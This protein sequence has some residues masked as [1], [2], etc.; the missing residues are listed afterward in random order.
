VA[1]APAPPAVPEPAIPVTATCA[2]AWAAALDPRGHDDA[3]LARVDAF[4]ARCDDPALGAE[5]G[6]LRLQF[7]PGLLP[8]EE[9]IAAADAWLAAHPG[10]PRAVEAR[11]LRATVA[12]EQ[13]GDCGLALADYERVAAEASG[14]LAETAAAWAERCGDEAGGKDR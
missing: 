1:A 11:F 10:H 3:R 4:L 13:L 12:R 8:G 6:L 2:E 14:N 9:A 5:A 7:L